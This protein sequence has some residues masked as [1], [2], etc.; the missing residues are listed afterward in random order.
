M[1]RIL[2]LDGV[3]PSLPQVARS[4]RITLGIVRRYTLE[5]H[6]NMAVARVTYSGVA[7]PGA[8]PGHVP[9]LLFDAY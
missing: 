5:P 6:T 1:V 9:R 8:P 3:N 4:R 7:L 2:T